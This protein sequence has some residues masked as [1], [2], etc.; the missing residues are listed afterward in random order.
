MFQSFKSFFFNLLWQPGRSMTVAGLIA[1]SLAAA[2]DCA[3]LFALSL[4]PFVLVSI[5]Q[6]TMTRRIDDNFAVMPSMPLVDGKPY[7]FLF[8]KKRKDAKTVRCHEQL[9]SLIRDKISLGEALPRGRYL[10]ITHETVLKVFAGCGSI[11]LDG[12]PV[13]LY[14]KR[15]GNTINKQMNGRCRRCA[16]PCAAYRSEPRMFYLVRFTVA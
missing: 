7:Y 14:R 2:V 5:W 15:L 9:R 1:F 8:Q 16:A 11:R 10:T 13:P 6:A 4:V 12:E 3:P